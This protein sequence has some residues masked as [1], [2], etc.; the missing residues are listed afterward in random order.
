M[1][2]QYIVEFVK[3]GKLMTRPVNTFNETSARMIA[4]GVY[5]NDIEILSVTVRE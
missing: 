1:A 2:Y 3:D 5:G 4:V